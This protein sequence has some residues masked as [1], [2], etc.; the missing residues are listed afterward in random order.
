MGDLCLHRQPY[1][2]KNIKQYYHF[3]FSF[4][5][6]ISGPP[7][8]NQCM[9][10]TVWVCACVWVILCFVATISI[11]NSVHISRVMRLAGL[12]RARLHFTVVLMVSLPTCV[13]H[14]SSVASSGMPSQRRVHS[15][16]STGR[17]PGRRADAVQVQGETLPRPLL[18]QQTQLVRRLFFLID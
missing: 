6:K 10:N 15:H 5:V 14:R 9:G 13:D 17:A 3:F 2:T 16:P 7:Q 8:I 12:S 18:R 11:V 1:Q 4:I